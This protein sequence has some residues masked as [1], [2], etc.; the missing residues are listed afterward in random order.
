MPYRETQRRCP[1]CASPMKDQ[2]IEG[3]TIATCDSCGSVWI[4][5]GGAEI[6]E[7]ATQAHVVASPPVTAATAGGACPRCA[8]RLRPLVIHEAQLRRCPTCRGTFIPNEALAAAMWL[9]EDDDRA[10]PTVVEALEAW[11]RYLFGR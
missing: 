8:A 9:T 4:D 10:P 6:G 5:G 3:A 7:A 1:G 11:V 2:P